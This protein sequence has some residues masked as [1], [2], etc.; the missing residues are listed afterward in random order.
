LCRVVNIIENN[1][2]VVIE[3]CEDNI[4]KLHKQVLLNFDKISE[5]S[6]K[7]KEKFLNLVIDKNITEMQQLPFIKNSVSIFFEYKLV[8]F[9]YDFIIKN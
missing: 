9:V 2:G 6:Q 5:I 3:N 7:E 8:V 4:K 1:E